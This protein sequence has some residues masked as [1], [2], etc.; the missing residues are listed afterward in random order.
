MPGNWRPVQAVVDCLPQRQTLGIARVVGLERDDVR[1]PARRH[2]DPV[3]FLEE[4]RL[5]QDAATDLEIASVARVGPAIAGDA[6]PH[7]L[8][9][10]RTIGFAERLPG[11]RAGQRV[12]IGKYAAA[13]DH[14]ARR[15][16]LEQ[17]QLAGLERAEARCRRRPEIDLAQVRLLAK[18][19][20]PVAIGDGDDE[21][22][23][24]VYVPAAHAK[25]AY[26]KLAQVTTARLLPS[27]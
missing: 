10:A 22:D 3:A 23:A 27:E 26:V 11:E 24:H 17:E 5:G 20:E 4:E 19:L 25:L 9:R 7:L 1:R 21:V 12:G 18:H 8:R 2:G 14:V 6:R 15:M 13:D 16:K